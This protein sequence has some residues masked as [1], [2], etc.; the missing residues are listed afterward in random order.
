MDWKPLKELLARS[1]ALM[2]VERFVEAYDKPAAKKLDLGLLAKR[3]EDFEHIVEVLEQDL[4]LGEKTDLAVACAKD[5]QQVIK[6][7]IQTLVVE[8]NPDASPENNLCL[9]G[10]F[11]SAD[12]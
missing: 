1:H 4:R 2:L 9:K 8:K 10:L 12:E 7:A 11:L 3:E 6:E 5:P